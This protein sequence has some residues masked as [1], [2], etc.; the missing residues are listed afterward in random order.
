ME[1]N[2]TE[3]KHSMPMTLYFAICEYSCPETVFSLLPKQPPDGI[4]TVFIISTLIGS[5]FSI[6]TIQTCI[7]ISIHSVWELLV[8]EINAAVW[9]ID[10]L[11][12]PATTDNHT[13]ALDANVYQY[14]WH[15]G[16]RSSE[17][18]LCPIYGV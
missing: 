5:I 13:N 11:I 18:V 6:M 7:N 15:Y 9:H 10:R 17:T 12:A 1:Q 2:V 3:S 14:P 4:I 8:A 16:F